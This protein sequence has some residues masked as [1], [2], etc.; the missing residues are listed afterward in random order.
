MGAIPLAFMILLFIAFS[1]QTD[2]RRRNFKHRS[3]TTT[4]TTTEGFTTTTEGFTTT[5][6]DIPIT[7]PD[8][9]TT[10]PDV[11][12]TTEDITTTTPYPTTTTTPCF[13]TTTSDI[14]ITTPDRTTTTPD[15]T[16]TTEDITTTT[17]Y[18][19]TTTTPYVTTT[20]PDVTTT[21]SDITTTPEINTTT[22]DVTTTTPYPTTTTPETT[23]ADP[24]GQC[25]REY[26][27]LNCTA[28]RICAPSFDALSLYEVKRFTCPSE[29]PYCNYTTG[30]CSNYVDPQ[31]SDI[32]HNGSNF[33]CMRDGYFPD[34]QFCSVY[35]HCQEDVATKYICE[36]PLQYNPYTQDCENENWF[37]TDMEEK[38]RD[39]YSGIKLMFGDVQNYFVYCENN[40]VITVDRCIGA[41]KFNFNSQLCVPTCPHEGLFPKDDDCA[42]YYQCSP[43]SHIKSSG[44]IMTDLTCQ[45]GQGFSESSYQC[46]DRSLASNCNISYPDLYNK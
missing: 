32:P 23:S 15:V 22:P 9:T 26:S 10:T 21:T 44:Y 34:P 41:Y 16:T 27:C 30:T 39:Y 31:C 46:V 43:R 2:A 19:T 25:T 45:E 18:P 24:S 35:Y 17:P 42:N 4:P 36:Y 20:T 14:P 38:C 12:T 5:T 8:R 28:A 40:S 1:T 13:T 6:S 29:M 7:T 11:T 3:S 33:I 37:C